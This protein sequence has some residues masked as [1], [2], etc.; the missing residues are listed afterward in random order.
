MFS[1]HRLFSFQVIALTKV[2]MTTALMLPLSW[3]TGIKHNCHRGYYHSSLHGQK[4]EGIEDLP[5]YQ[6]KQEGQQQNRNLLQ[7]AVENGNIDAVETLLSHGA[8]VSQPTDEGMC[9]LYIASMRDHV[10]VVKALLSSG[11]SAN[12]PDVDVVCPLHIA[13]LNGNFDVVEALVSSG[14]LVN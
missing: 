10:N 3:K 14:A 12:Q 2:T 8:S 1:F 9:P 5:E 11:A 7:F 6:K 4:K 13:S